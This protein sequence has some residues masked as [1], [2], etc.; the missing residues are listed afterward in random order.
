MTRLNVSDI[1]SPWFNEIK[2]FYSTQATVLKALMLVPMYAILVLNIINILNIRRI[3]CLPDIAFA[4]SNFDLLGKYLLENRTHPLLL[5][6]P[7][8][9]RAIASRKF[10][11]MPIP[12]L[13]LLHRLRLRRPDHPPIL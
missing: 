8:L 13:F 11:F 1:N 7:H 9:G 3:K 4:I 10:T 12:L 6:D 5:S 2:H